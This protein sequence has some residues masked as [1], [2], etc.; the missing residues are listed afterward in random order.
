MRVI[1]KDQLNMIIG[2]LLFFRNIFCKFILLLIT[3][4]I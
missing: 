3:I 2:K 1:T 4:G